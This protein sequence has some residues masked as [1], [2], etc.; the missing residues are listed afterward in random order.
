[1]P[2]S[3]FRCRSCHHETKELHRVD[4][5][6]SVHYRAYYPSAWTEYAGAIS[7]DEIR[8]LCIEPRS[9]NSIRELNVRSLSEKMIGEVA[10]GARG[11]LAILGAATEL[12]QA[13]ADGAEALPDTIGGHRLALV[14]LR[15]GQG[16]FR[17]ELLRK[18]KSR[19]AISGDQPS[20]VL[21]AAHLY[22]YAALGK[23]HSCG[24]LLLRRDLH[25]LFDLG[26][27]RIHPQ[28]S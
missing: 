22:S 8:S 23:H 7:L 18:F 1:M 16:S 3:D 10:E 25:R 20:Q 5:G 2:Q 26:L 12:L 24:G 15:V 28:T 4:E 11:A 14:R 17:S 6:D 9:I 21:D 13:S 19:C 27:I